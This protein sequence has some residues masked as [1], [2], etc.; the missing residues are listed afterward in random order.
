MQTW[1]AFTVI[2]GFV[3]AGA[4]TAGYIARL[5]IEK[6]IA[7]GE[8]KARAEMPS[9]WEQFFGLVEGEDD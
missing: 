9:R 8:A 2:I 3:I 7:Q 1:V 6:I 4:M 5:L